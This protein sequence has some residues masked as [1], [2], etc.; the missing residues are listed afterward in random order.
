MLGT[1]GASSLCSYKGAEG[2]PEAVLGVF[3][4]SNSHQPFAMHGISFRPFLRTRTCNNKC[5]N[6][7]TL[8]CY[9]HLLIS[10]DFCLHCALPCCTQHSV[11]NVRSCFGSAAYLSPSVRCLCVCHW[12]SLPGSGR[13][14]GRT[15]RRGSSV[16]SEI[17]LPA[18]RKVST[19]NMVTESE[20]F[21]YT[22]IS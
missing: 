7:A 22:L 3:M 4:F 20:Y 16:N 2:G 12:Q 13:N 6:I 17:E 18:L 1:T 14:S 11:C 10:L 8:F 15:S 5:R 19:E 21:L 9:H